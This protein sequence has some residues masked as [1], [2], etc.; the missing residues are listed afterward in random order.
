[1]ITLS[2]VVLIDSLPGLSAQVTGA[3]KLYQQRGGAVLVPELA[4][5]SLDAHEYHI[6]AGGVRRGQRPERRPATRKIVSGA[7]SEVGHTLQ[8]VRRYRTLALFLLAFLL[9][10]DGIQT[11]LSQASVFAKD[12]LSFS[13][14]ELI[15]LGLMSTRPKEGGFLNSLDV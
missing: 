9:Y 6:Q 15:G 14:N 1:M 7:L 2:F 12:V 8:N 3:N 13:L 11:V 5:Q 10:N 4:V